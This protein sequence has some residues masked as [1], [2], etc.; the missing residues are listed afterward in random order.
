LGKRCC[1]RPPN[2]ACA[3]GHYS[4]FTSKTLGVASSFQMSP[5]PVT[6]T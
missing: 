1:N 3:S 5:P 4:G 2:T 6:L